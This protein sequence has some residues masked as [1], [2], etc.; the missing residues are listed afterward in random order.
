MTTIPSQRR[1]PGEPVEDA[2]RSGAERKVIEGF[3]RGLFDPESFDV[4]PTPAFSGLS[5][6]PS[7]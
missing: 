2:G 7:R 3:Q 4:K 6:A 1:R 5:R